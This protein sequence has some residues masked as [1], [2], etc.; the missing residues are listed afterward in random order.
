[1]FTS[2]AVTRLLAV[3][4]VMRQ[5]ASCYERLPLHSA[6]SRNAFRSLV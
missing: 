6:T 3:I 4:R 5:E 1:L 2:V